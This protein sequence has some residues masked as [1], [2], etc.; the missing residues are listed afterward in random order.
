VPCFIYPWLRTAFE[1]GFTQKAHIHLEDNGFIRLTIP[2]NMKW[3]PGQH[4]FLR[5]TSFGLQ[6]FSSHPFTICSLP[7]IRADETSA[8]VF[9]IRHQGGLTKKLYEYAQQHPGAGTPVLVDGPY[10]GVNMQKHDKGG[11]LLVV[12]GGSGAGWMLPL[13]ELFI[14]RR[15]NEQVP[16]STIGDNEKQISENGVHA[17]HPGPLS[18]RVILATRD[19]NSRIWFLRTVGE[20][21]TGYSA[22]HTST[23]LDVQVHLTG[24]AEQLAGVSTKMAG[25]VV[26]P[27][28][29]SSSDNIEV[30]TGDEKA[31]VPGKEL[32]GR[33]SLPSIIHEEALMAT[34]GEH[35]LSVFVCGP[36]TM[37]NDVR[38]AVA[39][40]NLSILKGSKSG[41]VYLHSEHFSWA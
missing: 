8:L 2:T 37:Q 13:I 31:S 10:G 7:S 41:G 16:E 11:R 36:E 12:A 4:C 38:N 22:T 21:L 19:T 25:V 28:S 1:Y 23:E 32:G 34:D 14:R 5:F 9:Y 35:S 26:S 40:E 17:T 33:P 3:G 39:K 15:S 6:S 30:Q 20:L 18:L 29:A 27:A 24:D